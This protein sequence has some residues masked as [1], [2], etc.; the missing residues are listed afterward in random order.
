L[1]GIT[2]LTAT[3]EDYLE[4]IGQLAFEKGNARIRD[5]ARALSVR[6]PTVTAAL[7]R[8]S[9]KKLVHYAPYQAVTLTARGQ[10]LAQRIGRRHRVIRE[11][12][13]DVLCVDAEAANENACRMEH[14]IDERVLDKL[15]AFIDFVK[16]SPENGDRWIARFRLHAERMEARRAGTDATGQGAVATPDRRTGAKS[17]GGRKPMTTLKDLEPGDRARVVGYARGAKAYR[18]RL[19][20]MGLTRG[21]EFT[22]TRMAPLGDPVE[23]NLRGFNLSLRKSEADT[24]KVEKL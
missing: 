13:A 15:I 3:L 16:H 8:L 20:A 22:V 6:E 12:L 5:I 11:L 9:G 1:T 18:D 23:I 17:V 2:G 24:L 21:T 19:L 10:E 4:A 7:K 14:A